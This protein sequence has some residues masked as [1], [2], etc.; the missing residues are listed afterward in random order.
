MV[1]RTLRHSLLATLTIIG[2]FLTW[3]PRDSASGSDISSWSVPIDLA[4]EISTG[5]QPRAAADQAGNVH[6]VWSAWTGQVPPDWRDQTDAIFYSWWNGKHWSTPVDILIS[7]DDESMYAWNLQVASDGSIILVWKT[8][9]ATGYVQ[10]I[11]VSKVGQ[12]ENAQ[13]WKTILSIPYADM[14][15]VAID[16]LSGDW[17]YVYIRESTDLLIQTSKDQGL[18]WS[19]PFTIWNS[20]DQA[21]SVLGE[22][23]VVADRQ[24]QIHVVWQENNA[25]YD[26]N[27]TAVWYARGVNIGGMPSFQI[28]EVA[29]RKNQNDSTKGWISIC[30]GNDKQIHLVWSGGTG[31]REGRFHQWSPDGGITWSEAEPILLGLSGMTQWHGLAV[32]SSGTLHLLTTAFG[33]SDGLTTA[34][35]AFWKNGQWS[36][37]QTFM[38][39]GEVA[40]L[41][42]TEGNHLHGVWGANGQIAYIS[43][44]TDAPLVAS[45]PFS[46]T[47]ISPLYRATETP[48][49]DVMP[50]TTTPQPYNT[51]LKST[52]V[53]Q[54][55]LGL[56]ALIGTFASL[57][58]ILAVIIFA[59]T[60]INIR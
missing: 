50:P 7:P 13:N 37:F 26:W 10:N 38:P 4:D 51:A 49:A 9:T 59:L 3:S 30:L 45:V 52:G 6:V 23:R 55:N 44:Q 11:S 33:L 41:V 56:P 43:A 2:I 29:R 34:R 16:S 35:Y 57:M 28:R 31:S 17:Y 5:W 36:A 60:R 42:V 1:S 20:L 18:S 39:I 24:G 15:T 12:A 19:N 58:L 22:T 47:T 21:G 48:Q 40:N 53:S 46:G 27:P 25:E 14:G 32:D 54:Q 8:A